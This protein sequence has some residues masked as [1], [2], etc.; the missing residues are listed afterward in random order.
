[1]EP[2]DP[3]PTR[4]HALKTGAGLVAAPAVLAAGGALLA[5]EPA[6][7]APA[8]EPPLKNPLTA[9]PKPPFPKQ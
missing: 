7:K 4:R 6:K 3:T 8:D 5:Q 9:Y 2:V 1:M